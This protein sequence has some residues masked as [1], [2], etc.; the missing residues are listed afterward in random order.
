[1][2]K[3]IKT[4]KKLIEKIIII[5]IILIIIKKISHLHRILI[6]KEKLIKQWTLKQQ[7]RNQ[8]LYQRMK[9]HN[10]LIYNKRFNHWIKKREPIYLFN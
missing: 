2:I 5:K 6:I 4:L 7:W 1:M 10:L 8:L 3:L 9:F